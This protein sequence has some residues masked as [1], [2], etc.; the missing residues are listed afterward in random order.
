MQE[1]SGPQKRAP[2]P[3]LGELG[4]PK[5]PIRFQL[6]VSESR[7]PGGKSPSIIEISEPP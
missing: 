1:T 2:P 4:V 3:P 5:P 7:A 6:F